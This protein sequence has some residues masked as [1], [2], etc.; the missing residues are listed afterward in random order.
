MLLQVR[1]NFWPKERL[2]AVLLAIGSMPGESPAQ[3]SANV[4]IGEQIF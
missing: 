2:A 3:T 1:L 4:T